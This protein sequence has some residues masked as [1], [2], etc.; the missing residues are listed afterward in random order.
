MSDSQ[1]QEETKNSPKNEEKPQE[2]D[3]STCA[4]G[5]TADQMRDLQE[6]LDR[7]KEDNSF[8]SKSRCSIT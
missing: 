5:L 1:D 7:A 2:N 3:L 6:E 4:G 8:S